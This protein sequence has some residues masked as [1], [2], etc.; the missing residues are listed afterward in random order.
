MK[1]LLGK[2]N[3]VSRRDFVTQA[4]R[5]FLG[6][7]LLPMA[8]DSQLFA[9]ASGSK[10]AKTA[11]KGT[12]K[13]VIY[14]YM[15]GGMSHL[16]T[17]DTK[18]GAN[19]Q[20]PVESIG[21][22]AGEIQVSTH[23]A[24]T[25]EQMDKLAVIR[26]MNSTQGAH[27]QGQYLMHTGYIL[28]GTI[29]HPTLGS[30]VMKLGGKINKT[31]PG[32]VIIGGGSNAIGAGF[33]E[34][35][36]TPLAIGR[37]GL[38]NSRR[39]RG[40]T[41]NEFDKRLEM[42]GVIDRSFERRYDQKQVRAYKDMYKDAIRLMNSKELEVFDVNKEPRQVRTAYG[43]STFG[44]GC[45]LA[46]RLVQ[47]GVR[48]VEVNHGGWDTHQDNFTRVQGLAQTLDQG[49]SAL[50]ADLADK[51]MLDK[52]LVVVATEFGRT[53]TINGN[54]GRDHYPKAFTCLLGGGGIRGGQVYGKTDKT[55]GNI[56]EDPV[57][58]QDLH[59]TIGHALGLDLDKIIHSPSKRPFTLADKGK[60]VTALFKS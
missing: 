57:S 27:Q 33:M 1:E 41:Q 55:G 52:T 30:W 5:A 45:L 9:A 22:N 42:A 37:A 29:R 31:L 44:Q 26:S 10:A 17:F 2:M 12:A 43:E 36:Y 16:D 39:P 15:N 54:T 28:R 53:P 21:T 59:A 25:A 46:R 13:H 23:M 56:E 14:L 8:L 7:G 19:V 6:V 4:A 20:G 24:R 34:A 35:K 51:G 47:K 40:V 38:P 3:D 48:F 32:N 60:P 18:P 58:V 50:M 11:A 49:L